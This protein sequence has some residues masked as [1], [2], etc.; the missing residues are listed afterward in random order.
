[1]TRCGSTTCE[2]A[3]LA[4]GKDYRFQVRAHNAVG[5]SDWS[6]SLDAATPDA[7]PG[8]VGPIEL[9][10]AGDGTLTIRWTPPT[11]QTSDIREL[12]RVLAGRG[13][14]KPTRERRSRSRGSTTTRR[15]SPSWPRTTLDSARSAR[16][17]RSSRSARRRRPRRRRSPTSRPPGDT[18]VT[19]RVVARST[20]T[21]PPRCATPSSATASRW[22]SCTDIAAQ[23]DNSGMTYDGTIYTYAVRATNNRAVD[24]AK[25]RRPAPAPVG[26]G[27]PAGAVGRVVDRDADRAEHEA[28]VT[29]TVPASRGGD[30]ARCRSWSTAW[31]GR[32]SSGPAARPSTSRSVTTTVPTPSRLRCATRRPTAPTRRPRTC[33]PTVRSSP[34]SSSA[35]SRTRGVRRRLL[36]G[37]VDH[38]RRQQRRPGDGRS[39]PLGHR[40]RPAQRDPPDP[41]STS[42]PS[43]P[44]RR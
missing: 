39:R 18:A 30:V 40:A 7:K 37:L 34:D 15:S 4:N 11:T 21:G 44:G 35:S 27:R 26:G 19:H 8:L 25:S 14:G 23:C 2:V 16:P 29:F 3:G 32:P 1:M 9:V 10:R 41:A 6:A 20:P 28:R 17:R 33:R 43:R 36:P 42:R 5:W 24:D 13:Q 31:S 12:P 22:P 38:H